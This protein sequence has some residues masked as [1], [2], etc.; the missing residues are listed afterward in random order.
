MNVPVYLESVGDRVRATTGAPFH[1]TAEAESQ[2]AALAA[3]R[4][5]IEQKLAT[6]RVVNLSFGE[7][8]GFGPDSA[9][10]LDAW[11]QLATN[12][13][14]DEFDRATAEARKEMEAEEA[15]RLGLTEDELP[16]A[17]R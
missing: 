12:P 1:L 10:F 6:G 4:Q 17:D 9:R 11:H 7:G 3:V 13:L 5:Q 8:C 16:A 15:A 14:L 2:P